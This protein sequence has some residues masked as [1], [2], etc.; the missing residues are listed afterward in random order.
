MYTIHQEKTFCRIFFLGP[1]HTMAPPKKQ[2]KL[3]VSQL[4]KNLRDPANA[5]WSSLD[6][7]DVRVGLGPVMTEE[8][9]RAYCEQNGIGAPTIA[10]KVNMDPSKDTQQ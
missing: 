9:M 2:Q 10:G 5:D 7:K 6:P 8:Q 1:D 3:S 4:T